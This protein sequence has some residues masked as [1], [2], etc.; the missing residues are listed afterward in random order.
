VDLYAK[1]GGWGAYSTELV[2]VRDYDFRFVVLT[3][4]TLASNYTNSLFYLI[5]EI[6]GSEVFPV[7]EEVAKDQAKAAIAGSYAASNLNSSLI[8][9]VDNQPG[10]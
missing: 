9:T 3:A 6:I 10:L 1:N 7:L 8:I 5:L 2:L 4:S